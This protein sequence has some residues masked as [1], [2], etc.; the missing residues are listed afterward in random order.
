MVY[1]TVLA[2]PL[3]EAEEE[4]DMEKLPKVRLRDVV[5]VD[6][7]EAVVPEAA[8]GGASWLVGSVD[9]PIA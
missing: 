6:G 1:C 9:P 8:G 7:R 2:L 5:L 3:W 4:E